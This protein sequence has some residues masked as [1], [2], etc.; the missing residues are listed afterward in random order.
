[1]SCHSTVSNMS[2][3]KS[4]IVR[5]LDGV[6]QDVNLDKKAN[7]SELLDRVRDCCV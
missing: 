5:R 6:D 7:G 1:M 4:Y 2:H 3:L